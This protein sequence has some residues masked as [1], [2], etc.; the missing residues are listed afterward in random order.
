[1]QQ[2]SLLASVHQTGPRVKFTDEGHEAQILLDDILEKMMEAIDAGDAI[3]SKLFQEA[4]EQM[5]E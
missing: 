1:M 4:E 2:H 3:D 5:K